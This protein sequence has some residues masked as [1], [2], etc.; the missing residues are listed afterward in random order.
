MRRLK[1]QSKI[2]Q[3]ALGRGID[4]VGGLA[5]AVYKTAPTNKNAR[6]QAAKLRYHVQKGTGDC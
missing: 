6:I 5:R 4:S 2:L 3:E 1:K